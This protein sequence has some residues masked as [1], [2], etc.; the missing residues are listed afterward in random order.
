MIEKDDYHEQALM[1]L[2]GPELQERGVK[3]DGDK[4]QLALLPVESLEE[5]GKVLDF[6]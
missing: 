6:G 1:S 5:I 2:R 3:H 4:V